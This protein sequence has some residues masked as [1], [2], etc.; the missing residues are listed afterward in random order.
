MNA[1]NEIAVAAFLD[2]RLAFP[3]I[4]ALVAA[5]MEAHAPT[6]HASLDEILEADAWARKHT[7]AL[8]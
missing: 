6:L 4:W 5:T 8:R 1:A 2:D 3:R 7:A